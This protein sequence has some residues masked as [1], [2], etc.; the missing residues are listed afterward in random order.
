MA[1]E[2]VQRLTKTTTPQSSITSSLSPLKVKALQTYLS[3]HVR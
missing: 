3:Y 2:N 1:A